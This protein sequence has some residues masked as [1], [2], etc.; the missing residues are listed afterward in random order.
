MKSTR[1]AY[2]QD[3][4]GADLIVTKTATPS[5]DAH[6]HVGHHKE[7]RRTR[8]TSS[9]DQGHQGNLQL[10]GRRDARRRHR[11]QLEGHRR[12]SPFENPNDWEDDHV[13]QSPTAID[14]GG[15]CTVDMTAGRDRSRADEDGP[16]LSTP[17]TCTYDEAPTRLTFTNTATATW[18]AE[19]RTTRPTART[20]GPRRRHSVTPANVD[21]RV[22][23]R[24]GLRQGHRWHCCVGAWRTR[25]RSQLLDDVLRTR[26]W[27]VRHKAQHRDIHH[28]RHEH[29][30]SASETVRVCSYRRSR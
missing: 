30:G 27:H 2:S 25:R 1:R 22:R 10:H 11:Q 3:C 5:F 21:R 18:D 14:N 28:E 6:V 8:A 19:R 9:F 7:R 12:R 15:D 23:Q 13:G 29:A 24:D 16:E 17:Y 26:P 4:Q 20:T